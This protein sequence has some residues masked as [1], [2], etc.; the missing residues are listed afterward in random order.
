MAKRGI[1][2][3][4]EIPVMATLQDGTEISGPRSLEILRRYAKRYDELA[5]S[6]EYAEHLAGQA[7]GAQIQHEAALATLATERQAA[8][9]ATAAA[10]QEAT[11]AEAHAKGRREFLAAE[12]ARGQAQLDTVTAAVAAKQTELAELTTA[13]ATLKAKFAG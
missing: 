4:E 12:V 3:N 6:V 9:A 2:P 8:E 5:A 1:A 11:D 7:A 10:R 13:V